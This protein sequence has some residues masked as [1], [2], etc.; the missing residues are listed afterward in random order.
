ME[1]FY[2]IREYFLDRLISNWLVNKG[3]KCTSTGNYDIT[4]SHV[5]N[6]FKVNYGYVVAHQ[7]KIADLVDSHEQVKN[8]TTLQNETFH[9]TF[10]M[11]K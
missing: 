11:S 8:K 3:Y 4:F 2:K 7:Y 1:I 5:S 9:L 10:N 6:R